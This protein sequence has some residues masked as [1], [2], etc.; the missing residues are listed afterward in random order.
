MVQD[1]LP[2]LLIG[3]GVLAFL[4]LVGSGLAVL[5]GPRDI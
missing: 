1:T 5:R 3:A 4:L 2:A